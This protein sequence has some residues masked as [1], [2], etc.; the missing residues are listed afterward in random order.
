[1]NESEQPVAAAAAEVCTGETGEAGVA[2]GISEPSNKRQKLSH[3]AT[4]EQRER[5]HGIAPIKPE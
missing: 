2:S 5:R 4:T 1:M 3:N